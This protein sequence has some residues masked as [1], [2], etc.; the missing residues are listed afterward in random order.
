Y[1]DRGAIQAREIVPYPR[2]YEEAIKQAAEANGK[3]KV[4]TGLLY[5]MNDPQLTICD[6]GYREHSYWTGYIRN[7]LSALDADK[8]KEKAGE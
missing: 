1:K 4:L 7:L 2:P 5:A 3:K 8:A 6:T